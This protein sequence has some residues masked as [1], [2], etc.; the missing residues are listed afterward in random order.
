VT[1]ANEH[2]STLAASMGKLAIVVHGADSPQVHIDGD[3]IGE[4]ELRGAVVL[5]PGNHAVDVSA[6]GKKP[7]HTSV[8]IERGVRVDLSVDLVPDAPPPQAPPSYT[9]RNVGIVLLGVAGAVGIGA[10][11]ALLV[12]QNTIDTIKADCPNQSGLN[13][14]PITL[15]DQ[16][17]S[18]RATAGTLG[19]VA[20]TMGAIGIATAAVGAVLIA[21][22]PTTRGTTVGVVATGSAVAVRLGVAF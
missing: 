21:L 16:I 15:H 1:S 3:P 19:P 14:C 22:G 10:G 7:A 11:V 13:V 8:A 6:A 20:L 2:I 9:R 4:G 18:M 17:E 5:E 12:R